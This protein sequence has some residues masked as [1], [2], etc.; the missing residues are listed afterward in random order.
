MLERRRGS[1]LRSINGAIWLAMVGIC[2]LAVGDILRIFVSPTGVQI[3]SRA[4]FFLGV[5]CSFLL[6][7][8]LLGL[9]QG[10]LGYAVS[11]LIALR[12]PKRV[13]VPWN[14]AVHFAV[15]T[16]VLGSLCILL[17][18]RR[19]YIANQRYAYLALFILTA[20]VF[21]G[22]H[23]TTRFREK[24]RTGRW[25]RMHAYT[26]SALFLCIAFFLSCLAFPPATLSKCMKH[27]LAAAIIASAQ[28]SVFWQ[29]V[30]WRPQLPKMGSLFHNYSV[31]GAVAFVVAV[32]AFFGTSLLRQNMMHSQLWDAGL[33]SGWLFDQIVQLI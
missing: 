18:V 15:V 5:L 23:V 17:F 2:P 32:A 11:R 13:D 30:Y 12:G 22:A 21:C 3:D 27:A 19:G 29:Y 31:F 33:L 4:V 10:V 6:G 7:S 14:A 28:F 24:F 26:L 8:V 1:V 16:A 9:V 20:S 25:G